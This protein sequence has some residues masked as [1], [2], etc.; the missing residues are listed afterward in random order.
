MRDSYRGFAYMW[1]KVYKKEIL[2]EADGTMILF[3]ENLTLGG[4]VLYLAKVALN[5]KRA[6]YINRSFYHYYQRETSGCHTRDVSKLKDWL[7]AY[8]M[9]IALFEQKGIEREILSYV[10]RFLAYHSSNAAEIAYENKKKEMLK[11]F[12]NIMEFYQK[13]YLNLNIQ[14]P[15]RI[16]RYLRI[17]K[18]Q[19]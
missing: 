11:L 17:M 16:E 19:L 14:Y 8:E 4:D 13:S 6:K 15:E 1:D 3:D 10:E 12:Q 7:K 9:V 2:R 5:T 18:L